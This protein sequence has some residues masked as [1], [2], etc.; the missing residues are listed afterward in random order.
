MKI[1]TFGVMANA[2]SDAP[3]FRSGKVDDETLF[4]AAGVAHN[5]KQALFEVDKLCGLDPQWLAE[6]DGEVISPV[7]FLADGRAAEVETLSQT[8]R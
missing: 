6:V 5:L 8:F 2:L 1:T 4:K 7:E 3:Y